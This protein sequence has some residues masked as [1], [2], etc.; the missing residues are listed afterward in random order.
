VDQQLDRPGRHYFRGAVWAVRVRSFLAGEA[1]EYSGGHG[2]FTRRKRMTTMEEWTCA[3]SP[4]L[5]LAIFIGAI[6]WVIGGQR[7]LLHYLKAMGIIFLVFIGV[8]ILAIIAAVAIPHIK[9]GAANKNRPAT[10]ERRPRTEDYTGTSSYLVKFYDTLGKE[11]KSYATKASPPSVIM[12]DE[13]EPDIYPSEHSAAKWLVRKAS[14]EW[15]SDFRL[16]KVTFTKICCEDHEKELRSLVSESFPA[17]SRPAMQSSQPAEKIV[18]L[19][20]EL[21][22]TSVALTV[23]ASGIAERVYQASYVSKLWVDEFS[24]YMAS[25]SGKYLVARSGTACTSEADAREQAY[26]DAAR[27]LLPYVEAQFKQLRCYRDVREEELLR[28]IQTYLDGSEGTQYFNLINDQFIQ[29]F[30]RPYGTI[31]RYFL[32]IDYQPGKIAM[33]K[34]ACEKEFYKGL[35]TTASTLGGGVVLLGVICLLY[36]LVNSYTKGYYTWQLRTGVVIL[37]LVIAGALVCVMS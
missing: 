25:T 26:A 37:F 24:K 12:D 11:G 23:R 15:R 17:A 20:W 10:I 3:L 2:T 32:L 19:V 34:R 4:V 30:K 22:A 8:V 27:Q 35:T 29:S 1:G 36:W 16:G 31:W 13:F 14:K 33:L 21:N 28:F 6:L 7:D 18:D 5:G 9:E